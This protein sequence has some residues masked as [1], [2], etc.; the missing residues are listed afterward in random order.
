VGH[1]VV[2]VIVVVVVVVVMVVMMMVTISISSS[3]ES[4]IKFRTEP[5]HKIPSSAAT[6]DVIV[7]SFSH[8]I[9]NLHDV[10]CVE[11]EVGVVS[12]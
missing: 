8:V 12:V 6:D 3:I 2:V 7:T 10:A 1:T 4:L 5:R 11:T 9:L